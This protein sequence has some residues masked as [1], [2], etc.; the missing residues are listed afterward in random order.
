MV[1]LIHAY[2][3][4]N[5][6]DGLLVDLSLERLRRAGV[7]SEDCEVFA[8][9]AASFSDLAHVHQVGVPG[10]RP[11]LA[12]IPAGA[13]LAASGLERGTGGRLRL[14]TLAEMLGRA[15]ATVAVGGGYLRAGTAMSS[16]GTLLNH[17]PQ[18]GGAA[19]LAAPTLYLPQSVGP[20]RGPVGALVRRLL[21]GVDVVCVRDDRS[22]EELEPDRPVLRVPDLAVLRLAEGLDDICSRD[23]GGGPVVLVA[24][25][26]PEGGRYEEGL[27]ALARSLGA[28]VWATQAEGVGSKSDLAFYERLGIR[29]AG[30]LRDV[31]ERERPGV[32]ISTRLHGAIQAL[33]AGV[34]AI[35]LGYERKSWGAYDDLGLAAYVHG[36]RA[37]APDEVARQARKLLADPSEFWE[38][39]EGRRPPLLEASERLTGVLREYL[40]RA[41]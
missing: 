11:S 37:F 32:V 16:F 28:V 24:R 17:V 35:H 14:G 12:M 8:L 21:R 10:R 23:G 15:D 26:L 27:R 6:G 40:G 38:Q 29:S 2:S 25:E 20:L 31:L 18:L 33:L 36:A 9:D 13:Q 41:S 3:R 5:A 1:A 7:R 4:R 34:P 30:P 22:V 39:I 19:R